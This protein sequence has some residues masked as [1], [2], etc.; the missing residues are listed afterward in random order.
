MALTLTQLWAAM[1]LGDG[2]NEPPEPERT[3]LTLHHE[4][5]LELI[6]D[7][8]HPDEA[9]ESV[10]DLATVRFVGWLYDTP[11]TDGRRPVQNGLQACG[12]ASA[13]DEYRRPRAVA[14]GR[15][16]GSTPTPSGGGLTI[17]EIRRLL[18]ADNYWALDSFVRNLRTIPDP[19]GVTLGWVLTRTAGGYAF[20][21]IGESQIDAAVTQYLQDNPIDGVTTQVFDAAVSRLD[22]LIS[23]LDTKVQSNTTAIAKNLD[24]V[25]T[26]T[27][28]VNSLNDLVR[29]NVGS[30]GIAPNAIPRNAALQRDYVF[31]FEDLDVAWL[32]SKRVTSMEVWLKNTPFHAIDPWSPTADGT[33]TVNIN[34]QEA[35]AIALS[36]G[37]RIT[38]VRLVWRASGTFVALRN[39]WLELMP[40]AGVQD[41]ADSLAAE[42]K[43]RT[44]GDD[45]NKTIIAG[46]DA[47]AANAALATFLTAQESSTSVGIIEIT[48]NAAQADGH[49]YVLGDIVVF[50]PGGSA[51]KIVG[52][53]AHYAHSGFGFL[54]T[55]VGS[56]ADLNRLA[57]GQ[58]DDIHG[59]FAEV[60][61]DFR[62]TPQGLNYKTRDILWLQPFMP[63]RLG[64]KRLFNLGGEVTPFSFSIDD[65]IEMLN[66]RADP[67]VIAYPSGGL[68]AALTRTVTIL[69]DNPA[70]LN[71]A[72]LFYQ[73]LVDGQT[74][75]TRREWTTATNSVPLVIP[76]ATARLVGQDEELTLEIQWY[77]DTV[78]NNGKLVGLRRVDIP[79]VKQTAVVKLANEAAYNALAAKD[80]NT[81]YYVAAT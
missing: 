49:A 8:L 11:P 22:G 39:T 27:G 68:T 25:N 3:L 29:A 44:E 51:G 4:A 78:A 70:R 53:I 80:P 12:A 18:R 31:S 72:G 42:V 71:D 64:V 57:D 52:N 1:R 48:A 30:I 65:K 6:T 35:R 33:F 58:K 50:A 5:A 43:A 67:G 73:G 45:F 21:A 37:E 74:V 79:L 23:G 16:N 20:Q 40:A 54:S 60:T 28:R 76:L 13:L 17:D 46:E 36:G 2:V 7:Y 62:Y 69:L 59:E 10:I 41:V 15:T 55:Q 38:P 75:L 47:A 32:N 26:L 24:S 77:D 34:E 14:I 81:W 56:E 9:P 61:A 63:S 66:L 19:T